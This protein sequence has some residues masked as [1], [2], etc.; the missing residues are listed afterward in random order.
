MMNITLAIGLV[1]AIV[2]IGVTLTGI[3]FHWL[4]SDLQQLRTDMTTHLF[5][6]AKR[7]E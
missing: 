5:T 1:G 6:H 4:R 2:T 3:M 7:T